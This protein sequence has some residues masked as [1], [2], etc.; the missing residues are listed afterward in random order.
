MPEPRPAAA[1]D[2]LS[3]SSISTYLRCPRQW[4]YAYLE[5]LRRRP[6]GA[7]IRG[8]AV[9]RGAARNLSQKIESR[10]DLPVGDI[11]ETTEDAFRRAVDREGGPS[12]VDWEGANQARLLDSSIELAR[13]HAYEHAP[14]IDPAAVQL[15][16]K[17]ALPSGRE[18]VGYLDYVQRDG[19]VGDIKTGSK[20]MGQEAA[21]RDLQPSAYAYLVGEP[22][23][24]EFARLIDTG[25]RRGE[26][27]VTTERDAGAITWFEQLASEVDRAIAAEVF[28]PNPNGWHCSPR[29][30]G[31]WT[32]CMVQH[33]P[34][35]FPG[36]S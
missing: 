20:R 15:E 27:I 4:A 25:T 18:F 10:R 3:F 7:L 35:E 36:S 16:L 13:I 6:T 14:H 29:Y 32:R 19:R 33:R 31:F 9:D 8:E 28:P 1:V 12:E 22:I 5:G 11:L 30:C 17:R 24:F 21:D 26:E 23:R 34:P 2:H